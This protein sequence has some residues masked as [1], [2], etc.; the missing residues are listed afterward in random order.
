MAGSICAPGQYRGFS[1]VLH[2]LDGLF[3]SFQARLK[4][5]LRPTIP[6]DLTTATSPRTATGRK[7]SSQCHTKDR[8]VC[9]RRARP[10]VKPA[11][12]AG[13]WDRLLISQDLPDCHKP[14]LKGVIRLPSGTPVRGLHLATTRHRLISYPNQ[15]L[16]TFNITSQP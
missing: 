5:H 15:G 14:P 9:R 7:E 13:T 8:M 6:K 2:H 16:P 11:A 4:A 10:T 12:E 3:E 1:D